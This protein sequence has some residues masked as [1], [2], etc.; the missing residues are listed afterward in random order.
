MT[1]ELDLLLVGATGFTGRRA[2]AYLARRAPG[3]KLGLLARDGRKLERLEL[4]AERLVVDLLD[5]DAVF[6]AVGRAR[7]VANTAGP[8]AKLGDNVVDACVYHGVHYCDITGETAWVR[9]LI[10]RHHVRARAAGTRIVPCSGF[11]SVPADLAVLRLARDSGGTLADV[12]TIYSLQGGLN[13]GTLA[14]ALYLAEHEERGELADPWLLVPGADPTKTEREQQRDPHRPARIDGDW[15]APFFMGPINRRIVQRSHAL[16]HV[17][18]PPGPDGV[19][20][21][22]ESYGES[23]RYREWMTTGGPLGAFAATAALGLGGALISTGPG[24]WMARH[25]GPEPGKGPSEETLANGSTRARHRAMTSTNDELRLE[26]TAEGDPGNAVTVLT[27]GETALALAEP[28]DALELGTPGTGG[29]LTPALA[30]GDV[31][32]A[33]LEHTGEYRLHPKSAEP[34]TQRTG[35]SS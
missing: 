5:R 22:L 10:A 26:F 20:R 30:L 31:L 15:V 13:G 18:A 6:R 35:S 24:R 17:H 23:F 7:V 16:C 29:V 34:L 25:L 1:R 27:L 19:A 8:F 4:T 33:R 21:P 9:R 32:L 14:S 3:L 12:D 11:D 2:A 28:P